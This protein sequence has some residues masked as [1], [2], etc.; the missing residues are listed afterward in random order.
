M[1]TKQIIPRV[2]YITGRLLYLFGYI[3]GGAFLKANKK[4]SSELIIEAG[5][6][7]WTSIAFQEIYNSASEFFGQGKVHKV[8][9]DRNR[10][11]ISQVRDQTKNSLFGY[12]FFDPRTANSGFWRFILQ[13]LALSFYLGASRATPIVMITDFSVRMWRYGALALTGVKGIVFNFVNTELMKEHFFHKRI[14]SLQM[15]PMSKSTLNELSKKYHERELTD[16]ISLGFV[17]ALYPLRRNFF[18]NLEKELKR[19]EFIPRVTLSFEDKDYLGDS[20]SYFNKLNMF[21]AII[22]T[23]S[24]ERCFDY[25]QD[26][27][28][29]P[30]MVF[31]ITEALALNRLLICTPVPGMEK[32]LLPD[33]DY[34]LISDP[35][36]IRKLNQP[37][38]DLERIRQS[39]HERIAWHI[40]NQTFWRQLIQK[41]FHE[42]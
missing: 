4:S 6:I 1:I 40:E 25:T 16:R 32:Y 14:V 12:Y 7:G 29:I 26:R 39:G 20:W 33:V 24:Q 28:D 41:R 34:V 10:G 15:F 23:T 8:I 11:Y 13:A 22:T 30:Q 27:L 19:Q 2:F 35:S 38:A 18:E 3:C 5:T 31:R 37:V 21:D 9:I 17:G 36:D 42:K